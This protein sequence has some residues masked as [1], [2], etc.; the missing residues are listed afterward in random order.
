MCTKICLD[1]AG[2]ISS[3]TV[4]E[5]CSNQEEGDTRM[6][7]HAL[8]AS[9]EGH[10]RLL[11]KSSDTDVEV[12]ARHLQ[13]N[14]AA[15]ITLL[16]GTRRRARIISVAR[17]CEELGVEVCRVLP[18][19]HALT[20]CDSVSGFAGKGK[21]PA[22]DIVQKDDD[23]RAIICTISE[24]M[25]PREDDLVDLERFACRLYNDQQQDQRYQI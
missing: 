23:L 14:I 15:E 10:Q 25:P 11:I 24:H 22:L 16:T 17:V 13:V 18:G 1:A 12:I 5:L 6:F 20:G 21:K 8:H 7:L 9:E 2:R 19:L 3:C 4:D